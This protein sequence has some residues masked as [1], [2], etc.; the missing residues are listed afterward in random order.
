MDYCWICD[1]VYTNPIKLLDCDHKF[2]FHCLLCWFRHSLMKTTFACPR[3]DEEVDEME[4]DGRI[5]WSV[6]NRQL[7]WAHS[8]MYG[9]TPHEPLSKEMVMEMIQDKIDFAGSLTECAV[10]LPDGKIEKKWVWM[11]EEMAV[12]TEW[13][14]YKLL[15]DFVKYNYNWMLTFSIKIPDVDTK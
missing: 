2:C 8:F 4:I 15:K 1:N 10:D 14:M 6:E 11:R 7:V 3:C 5:L 12:N 9:T 13:A